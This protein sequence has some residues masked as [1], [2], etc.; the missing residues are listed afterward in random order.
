M[1]EASRLVLT[2]LKRRF[3]LQMPPFN[4][5]RST[6]RVPILATV[7]AMSNNCILAQPEPEPAF[8]YVFPLKPSATKSTQKI[9]ERV[10]S[11]Q[12]KK[13]Q[14]WVI[15]HF[16]SGNLIDECHKCDEAKPVCRKCS[17]HF[18]NINACDYGSTSEVDKNSSSKK[19]TSTSPLKN[20]VSSR[21]RRKVISPSKKVSAV[22]EASVDTETL[23]PVNPYQCSSLSGRLDP[24]SVIPEESSP[25][26]HSLMH[27]CTTPYS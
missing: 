14:G 5:I 7:Q 25:R 1:A 17:M 16:T 15:H 20:D 22:L 10:C 4:L 27:H 23:L 3:K 8:S 6:Y 13:S 18:S 11:M 26:V 19:G 12:S 2:G 9:P 24:F 21:L